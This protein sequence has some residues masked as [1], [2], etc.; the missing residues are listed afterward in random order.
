MISLCQTILGAPL[1]ISNT[2]YKVLRVWILKAHQVSHQD[3]RQFIF[4]GNSRD[5]EIPIWRW[6]VKLSLIPQG[7]RGGD[8]PKMAS[9]AEDGRSIRG[10][11]GGVS[12]LCLVPFILQSS[13]I[14]HIPFLPPPITEGDR[15]SYLLFLGLLESRPSWLHP[16]KHV[17]GAIFKAMIL[18]GAEGSVR[19]FLF[20]YLP[21]V[22]VYGRITHQLSNLNLQIGWN[23]SPHWQ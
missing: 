17:D 1:I 3:K 4:R 19:P 8:W 5:I 15:W 22:W 13:G 20:L 9:E 10:R 11:E 16:C 23:L 12:H 2:H 7:L 6:C 18:T 21:S 14:T